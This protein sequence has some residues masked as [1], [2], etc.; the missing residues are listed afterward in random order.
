MFKDTQ[1][2]K[3]K[4]QKRTLQ[5]NNGNQNRSQGLIVWVGGMAQLKGCE[6]TCRQASW[7]KVRWK[8]L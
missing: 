2:L 3:M 8:E 5:A 4:G 6:A 1:R 7:K